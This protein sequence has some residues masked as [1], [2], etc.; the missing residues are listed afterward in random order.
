MSRYNKIVFICYWNK[1]HWIGQRDIN[2]K[3]FLNTNID[4]EEYRI[5][6]AVSTVKYLWRSN[7]LRENESDKLHIYLAIMYS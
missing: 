7:H 3:E 1:T 6:T 5:I 4:G 2:A